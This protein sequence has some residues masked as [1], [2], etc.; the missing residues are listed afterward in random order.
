M[1]NPADAIKDPYIL[2]FLHLKEHHRYSEND[3]ENA[4]IDKV[5]YFLPGLGKGFTFVA[6]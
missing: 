1:E 5:E 3:L 4:L 6:R 2:E